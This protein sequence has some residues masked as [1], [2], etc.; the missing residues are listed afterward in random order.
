ML[1]E[2]FMLIFYSYFSLLFKYSCSIFTPLRLLPHSSWLSTLEPTPFGIVYVSVI[3]VLWWTF[4]Y[5]PPLSPSLL[6][7]GYCQFVLYFNISGYILLACLFCWLGSTYRWDHMVFVFHHLAYFT[8]VPS[9]FSW[10]VGAPS[11]FLLCSIPLCK[12]TTFDPLIYWCVFRLPPTLAIVNCAAM[13]I[14]VHR[15]FW[16][17]VL[18]CFLLQYGAGHFSAGA[19]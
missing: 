9:M 16:I 14:G 13:N 4:P 17:G 18:E 12:G 10:R 11:F 3:H 7:S 19:H 8:P 5:F 6:P 2:C 1:S 15:Y